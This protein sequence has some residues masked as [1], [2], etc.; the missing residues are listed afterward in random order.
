M[1]KAANPKATAHRD[2]RA[3]VGQEGAAADQ[4]NEMRAGQ[5]PNAQAAHAR[6]AAR[7]GERVW[8]LLD[9]AGAETGRQ[10]EI[11]SKSGGGT[12]VVREAGD[13]SGAVFSV[14]R[15]QLVGPDGEEASDDP[16]EP[17]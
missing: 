3:H 16:N 11:V 4:H 14:R 5:N 17:T 10:V 15:S 6:N 12:I 13:T 8:T 1:A 7:A 2:G 9:E